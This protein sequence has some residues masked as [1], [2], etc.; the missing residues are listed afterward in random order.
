[1]FLEL[2]LN[3]LNT[4]TDYFFTSSIIQTLRHSNFTISAISIPANCYFSMTFSI[5]FTNIIFLVV[6]MLDTT[7]GDTT[8]YSTSPSILNTNANTNNSSVCTDYAMT[9]YHQPA[10]LS[11]LI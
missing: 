8:M 1:M 7:N 9:K 3:Q 5:T 4:S 10:P 6:L 11:L 2:Q